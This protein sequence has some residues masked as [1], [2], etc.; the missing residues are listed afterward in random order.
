MP[1]ICR[2][3]TLGGAALPSEVVVASKIYWGVL[4]DAYLTSAASVGD[5]YAAIAY[6]DRSGSISDG[7]T[8]A[9]PPVMTVE[10]REHF[11]LLR[12]LCGQDHYVIASW[13]SIGEMP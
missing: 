7:S 11:V 8:V 4:I 5:R 1:N 9:T 3:P 13:Q 12:S 2:P 6:L 10:Q